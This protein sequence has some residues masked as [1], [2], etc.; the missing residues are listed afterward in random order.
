MTQYKS[1]FLLSKLTS[2]L[3]TLISL[4]QVPCSEYTKQGSIDYF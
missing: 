4:T 3:I 1:H 2:T